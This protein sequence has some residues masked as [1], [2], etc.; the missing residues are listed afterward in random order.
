M[1]LNTVIY[2]NDHIQRKLMING[3]CIRH[4][5]ADQRLINFL[6]T[7]SE[8]FLNI[9]L[10]KE[11]DSKPFLKDRHYPVSEDIKLVIL[12]ERD[13]WRASTRNGKEIDVTEVYANPLIQIED[14]YLTAD[15][16]F[17]V[18]R[19][20]YLRGGTGKKG[21][22]PLKWVPLSEMSNEWLHNCIKFNIEERKSYI[23]TPNELY[24]IELEYRKEKGIILKD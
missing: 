12:L 22:E 8:S 1:K 19:T 20:K 4:R 7:D 13:R 14:Y 10:L 6:G 21:N 15:Q 17:E 2:D 11:F 16:P 23:N 24:H 5:M 9:Y 18:I 3:E